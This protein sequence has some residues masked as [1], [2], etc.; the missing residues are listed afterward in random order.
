M[1]E[2][3]Q[4][5]VPGHIFDDGTILEE[6]L[7]TDGPRFVK[8][9]PEF[10]DFYYGKET[11]KARWEIVEE[12][13]GFVP[14]DDDLLRTGAVLLPSEPEEYGDAGELFAGIVHWAQRYVKLD[15]RLLKLA[16]L[17]T[18]LGWLY[19]KAPALPILNPR[20]ASET[21][22]T[23]LG[24]ILWSVSFR[25]IKG[26]GA[27]SLS[28]LFRTSE[29]WRGTLYINEGDLSAYRGADSETGQM[30]RFLN[31]R[32]EKPGFIW[33]TNKE[34]MQV[35]A[36]RVFGPTIVVTRQG[37]RDDALESRCLVTPMKTTTREDIP[38]NLPPWFWNEA[39]VWRNRL[40]MFRLRNYREFEND[41]ELRFPGLQPRIQQI[42]Q[43]A[44]SLARVMSPS[45]FAEV[46][47]LA[48]EL[49]ERVIGDRA[50]SID[51]LIVQEYAK[52]RLVLGHERVKAS[53]I[54]ENLS[55]SDLI[56]GEISY[57]KVGSR[58]K[59]L[60][61]HSER[62]EGGGRYLDIA[63]DDLRQLIGKY[64]PEDERK[65]LLD[66][67]DDLDNP[68]RTEGETG[69]ENS[70]HREVQE[71]APIM[72]GTD[73]EVISP[74]DDAPPAPGRA[75][76]EKKKKRLALSGAGQPD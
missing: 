69:A 76:G 39:K 58:A 33:R 51:G 27:L 59:I 43:P 23:R 26:D 30:V 14:L 9:R 20:A 53:E 29:R 7:T 38:L 65:E 10:T 57:Q 41:Y 50:E 12:Y 32:Y 4:M 35:E 61:F 22:K 34:S 44:A 68:R 3:K 55:D 46:E 64:V 48:G 37:F 11:A 67:P 25:G 74:H 49:N 75:G 6:V 52:H 17:V 24:N 18:T 5:H 13:R 21:G 62:D 2:S 42:L 19:E 31:A 56:K 70:R 60:G 36:F 40:L 72:A 54:A 16:V 47:T 63:R 28:S 71:T 1:S 8:Y 45:L 73:G 15:E 66:N